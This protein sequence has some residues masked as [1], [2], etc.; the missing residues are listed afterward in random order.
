MPN[1]INGMSVTSRIEQIQK[2]PETKQ[3]RGGYLNPKRL[4]VDHISDEVIDDS[5]EN[6]VPR[7]MGLAV[8]YLCRVSA[9]S[10]PA[11][12]F[13]VSLAGADL[14][15]AAEVAE[16]YLEII[17]S[18]A[19]SGRIGEAS[20]INAVRLAYYDMYARNPAWAAMAVEMDKP[21]PDSVTIDHI[22][23][24]IARFM[25]FVEKYGPTRAIGFTFG[26]NGYSAVVSS[27]DGDFV[28]GDMLVDMKVT[29]NRIT[30]KHTLQ[31]LMYYVMGRHSGNPVFD[32]V[33]RIGIFNPRDG[34]VSFVDVSEI[35]SED[36]EGIEKYV[37][38]YGSKAAFDAVEF[39]I[40]RHFIS[41]LVT[42]TNYMDLRTDAESDAV[43][44]SVREKV[45]AEYFE[46]YDVPEKSRDAVA[47]S[48]D[49]RIELFMEQ[50]N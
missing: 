24:M 43:F 45:L 14:A 49:A 20:V 10:D 47:H 7:I 29:K 12:A 18:E 16:T 31:I 21:D 33:S 11:D 28:V 23:M 41:K 44:N 6:I 38:C 5:V 50:Y 32:T 17:V 27:G 25:A 30:A 26:P 40:V 1:V 35:D 34:S 9:G 15:G 4:R 37:I 48:F 3:P 22:L 42:G 36:I 8:D 19:H 13:R 46:A 2:F 39:D